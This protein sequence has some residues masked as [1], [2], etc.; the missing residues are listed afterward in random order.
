[1]AADDT[2]NGVAQVLDVVDLWQPWKAQCR[3]TA[4]AWPFVLAVG[5]HDSYP[6]AGLLAVCRPDLWQGAKP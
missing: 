4:G 1:M 3:R 2:Q 5:G 6:E